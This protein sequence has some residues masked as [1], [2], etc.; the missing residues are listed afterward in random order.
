MVGDWHRMSKAD[1][2]AARAIKHARWESERESRR[3]VVEV[4]DSV[5]PKSTLTLFCPWIGS[6][7]KYA[8]DCYFRIRQCNG[9]RLVVI[10]DDR[11]PWC[12]PESFL[13]TSNMLARLNAMGVA[14]KDSSL[15]SPPFQKVCDLRPLLADA[16]HEVVTSTHWGWC[17]FDIVLA[18]IQ[19]LDA[20]QEEFFAPSVCANGP[21]SIMRNTQ[22]MRRLYRHHPEWLRLV[23][24]DKYCNF[25]EI[26]MTGAVMASGCTCRLE[27][28]YH[29]H[30]GMDS[31]TSESPGVVLLED[32][33][34]VDVIRP[35]QLAM[36][37]F[38]HWHSWPAIRRSSLAWHPPEK[39]TAAPWFILPWLFEQ[40]LPRSVVDFGCNSG[41][42]L[43]ALRQLQVE[44]IGV[45]G[46]NMRPHISWPA[47][48]VSADLSTPLD[49]GRHD[50]AICVE[51]AE[52]IHSSGAATLVDN[53]TRASDWVLWSAAVPGQGGF[54]HVNCQP[55]EY[56]EDLFRSR[57]FAPSLRVREAVATWPIPAWYK[58]NIKEFHRC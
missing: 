39:H 22:E 21:L 44:S 54:D 2:D 36:F 14:V 8:K 57:G 4:R 55:E 31:R 23:S 38:P 12:L 15:R 9:V 47:N 20:I 49:V 6:F 24:S 13:S 43:N 27:N 26:G 29:R 42:W 17:D 41:C 3:R 33:T 56:W 28:D 53:V 52:H 7:P 10:G 58:A 19:F 35:R 40:K 32:G 34:L 45:D 5:V 48:F 51:V 25:D 46:D 16:F 18:G 1:K 50:M 30:S 37:H 11:P